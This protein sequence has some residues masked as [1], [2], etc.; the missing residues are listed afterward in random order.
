MNEVNDFFTLQSLQTFG[1]ATLATTILANTFRSL[2]NKNPKIFAFVASILLCIIIAFLQKEQLERYFIVFING[3]LVYCT[4][5]GLN[6]QVSSIK[7]ERDTQVRTRRGHQPIRNV[8]AN[9]FKP[10]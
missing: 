3:C 6:N 7:K 8:I 1:G 10:W 2:T 5:T 4:A 9:F